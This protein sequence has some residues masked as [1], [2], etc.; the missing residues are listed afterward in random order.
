MSVVD[1]AVR[2]NLIHHTSHGQSH[3]LDKMGLERVLDIFND[4]PELSLLG[5][6]FASFALGALSAIVLPGSRSQV[7]NASTLPVKDSSR[8]IHALNVDKTV[9]LAAGGSLGSKNASA[10][11][12]EDLTDGPNRRTNGAADSGDEGS[13]DDGSYTSDD[14][15][16]DECKL[17]LVLRADLPQLTKTKAASHCAQATLAN[18]KACAS[19]LELKVGL[20]LRQ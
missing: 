12:E 11:D 6:T 8:D 3:N 16:D 2:T 4:L 17:V 10:S 7:Q 18:F 5:W 9:E 13:S 15:D 20:R 19:S 1:V 14:D